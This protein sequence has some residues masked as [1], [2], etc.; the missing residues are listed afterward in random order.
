MQIGDF[1]VTTIRLIRSCDSI[2]NNVCSIYKYVS[3]EA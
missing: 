3:F 2:A 1:I